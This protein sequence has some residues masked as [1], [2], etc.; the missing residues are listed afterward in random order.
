MSRARIRVAVCVGLA[1]VL[2]ACQSTRPT[3]PTNII[4]Y[5]DAVPY[6][7]L[8]E[9]NGAD[10]RPALAAFQRSCAALMGRSNE[11]PLGGAGY[12]GTIGDWRGVCTDA[13]RVPAGDPRTAQ[14]YFESQFVPYAVKAEPHS[15]G[16]FTGYYEPLLRGSRLQHDQY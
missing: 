5:L 15:D 11:S 10:V 6:A 14:A 4:L 7:S 8:T 1:A 2:A 12:A 13:S 9:W 3:S 16:L